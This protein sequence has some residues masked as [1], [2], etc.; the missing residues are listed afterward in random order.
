MIKPQIDTEML[1]QLA[2]DSIATG[3]H[4]RHSNCL[5]H[6]TQAMKENDDWYL[7]LDVLARNYFIALYGGAFSEQFFKKEIK[8]KIKWGKSEDGYIESKCDRFR[9]VPNFWGRCN[10]QDFTVEYKDNDKII[11]I[12][13]GCDTQKEAKQEAQKWLKKNK[14]K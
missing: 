11:K 9:I 1:Y 12:R 10:P 5:F 3:E 4:E 7:G 2:K 6:A 14:V 13:S 8:V